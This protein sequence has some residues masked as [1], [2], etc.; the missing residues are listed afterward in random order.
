MERLA[1]VCCIY[2]VMM[3]Y[4]YR[5]HKTVYTWIPYLLWALV[6]FLHGGHYIYLGVKQ[7]RCPRICMNSSQPPP[8]RQRRWLGGWETLTPP[9]IPC[10]AINAVL[11]QP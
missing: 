9:P 3:D 7:V 1:Q 10:L 11:F 4:E 5:R 6:G 2:P 8:W